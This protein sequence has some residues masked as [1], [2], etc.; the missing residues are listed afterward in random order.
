MGERNRFGQFRLRRLAL[1]LRQ[2]TVNELSTTAGVSPEVV[3]GFLHAL[4]QQGDHLLRA[5]SLSPQGP[6]RPILRYTLTPE[7]AEIL[8]DQNAVLAKELNEIAF[9]ENPSLRPMSRTAQRSRE[10]PEVIQS[11]L[12]R[13]G[14]GLHIKGEITGSEDIQV[15]GCVEG[16]IRLDRSKVTVV[17]S[18]KVEGDITARQVVV[19]GSVKGNVHA[20][21]RIE[22]KKDGFVL[23]D[24]RT[25]RIMIE[26]GA[27]FKGSIEIDRTAMPDTEMNAPAGADETELFSRPRLPAAR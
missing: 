23:G 27:F 1:Q 9:Q 26:D 3:Y 5:D 6:G 25:T 15:D 8:A 7:G 19:Y 22:I 16:L 2:F 13:I 14:A 10:V 17:S 12:R 21:D 11:G 24:L 20:S 18:A 4:K